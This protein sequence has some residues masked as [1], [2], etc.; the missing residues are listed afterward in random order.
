MQSSVDRK[1]GHNVATRGPE[2]TRG[3]SAGRTEQGPGMQAGYAAQGPGMQAEKCNTGPRDAGREGA[4][5]HGGRG[6]AMWGK[7]RYTRP[8]KVAQG[9]NWGAP[10]WRIEAGMPAVQ[11]GKHQ[12]ARRLA[13]RGVSARSGLATRRVGRRQAELCGAGGEVAGLPGWRRLGYRCQVA[14]RTPLAAAA[15]LPAAAGGRRP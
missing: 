12:C 7:L 15:Q 14:R 6:A 5:L 2:K 8:K 11:A 13:C 3:R 10:A 9:E 1:V 4:L